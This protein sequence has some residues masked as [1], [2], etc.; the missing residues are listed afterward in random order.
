[1]GEPRSHKTLSRPLPKIIQVVVRIQ[2]LEAVELMVAL[3]FFRTSKRKDAET[4]A[5]TSFGQA[6][7]G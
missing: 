2:C 4:L 6:H 1:M 3:I 7:P 5:I